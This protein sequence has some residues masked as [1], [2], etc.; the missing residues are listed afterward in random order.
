MQK[1][2]AALGGDLCGGEF[3][4]TCRKRFKE[5]FGYD[6][7]RTDV[8]LMAKNEDLVEFLNESATR[9]LE[10]VKNVVKS[11]DP[12]LPLTVNLAAHYPKHIRDGLDYMYTVPWAGNWLSGPYAAATSGG[13]PVLLGPGPGFRKSPVKKVTKRRTTS[14]S[15]PDCGYINH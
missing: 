6:A 8:E 1:H 13:K 2:L 9:M 5:R 14:T 10:D 7:P 4:E 15:D 11:I 3:V 12:E